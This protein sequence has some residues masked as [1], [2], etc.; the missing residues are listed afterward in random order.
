[1][2]FEF[3]KTHMSAA[4]SMARFATSAASS[5]STVESAR[6]AA[7]A[8]LRAVA[9]LGVRSPPPRST[10]RAGAALAPAADAHDA[11]RGLEDVARARELVGDA[12]VR[13]EDERLEAPQVLVRA[14]RLRQIDARARE[15]AGVL[16]ELLLEALEERE[17]VGRG[18]GEAHEDVVA[19]A[20]HLARVALDDNVAHGDLP[21]ADHHHLAAAA[22]AQDR[23]AVHG[24]V[25]KRAAAERR[26]DA[27]HAA[28][29]DHRARLPWWVVRLELFLGSCG[30]AAHECLT[31]A[32]QGA[33]RSSSAG[34]DEVTR[35]RT[36]D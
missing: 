10:S 20:A 17:G 2:K 14:P 19:D 11:V 13:D 36:R 33:R 3:V 25:R 12:A 21:V 1:M 18:P 16:L 31:A 7:R 26:T 28:R 34:V 32:S 30:D 22:H 27:Q 23:R 8:Y 4:T 15:L 9:L 5:P 29:A 35:L 24:R 6:A